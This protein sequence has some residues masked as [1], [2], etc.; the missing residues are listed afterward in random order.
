MIQVLFQTE[1]KTT[2]LKLFCGWTIIKQLILICY[3]VRN[4][5]PGGQL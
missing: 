1:L 4:Q 5:L 3:W 2:K